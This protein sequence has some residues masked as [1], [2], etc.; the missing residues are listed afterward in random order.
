[1][2]AISIVE[3]DHLQCDRVFYVDVMF[4]MCSDVGIVSVCFE[5]SVLRSCD[6][7]VIKPYW[8]YASA[9]IV[10]LS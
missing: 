7:N 10:V 6:G 8:E 3:P 9:K 1:M 2:L 4:G 5:P